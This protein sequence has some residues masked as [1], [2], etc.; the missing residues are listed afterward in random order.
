[1][2]LRSSDMARL[3]SD[4]SKLHGRNHKGWL[5]EAANAIRTTGDPRHA[6]ELLER[7]RRGQRSKNE[8]DTIADVNHWLEQRLRREPRMNPERLLVELG[9]LRR[10]AVT[11]Q[12][13]HRM[14]TKHGNR[15]TP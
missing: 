14:T 12:A 11:R 8:R 6:V 4:S 15:G 5:A 2:T 7:L 10:M 13:A 9:W 1:M 3:W